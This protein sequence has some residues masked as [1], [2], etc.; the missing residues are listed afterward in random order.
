MQPNAQMCSVG[1]VY[2]SDIARIPEK[3][4][5]FAVN[6]RKRLPASEINPLTTY[7]GCVYSL[8]IVFQKSPN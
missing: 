3:I 6:K 4:A 8:Q 5:K 7:K 2:S 1:T